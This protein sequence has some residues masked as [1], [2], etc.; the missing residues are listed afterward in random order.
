MSGSQAVRNWNISLLG[1]K[2]LGLEFL[3]KVL[4]WK[5]LPDAAVLNK[6]IVVMGVERVKANVLQCEQ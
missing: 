3:A 4:I 5:F 6:S 2:F 1:R